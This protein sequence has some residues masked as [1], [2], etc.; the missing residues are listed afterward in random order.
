MKMGQARIRFLIPYFGK[1]PFWMPFFLQSCRYNPSIEWLFFSDCGPPENCPPNVEIRDLSYVGYCEMV[2]EQL[3]IE[4]APPN[5]YKLCDLKPALGFVH[6][7]CLDGF[8]F[9]G[10]G[11]ID[12]VYGNLRRYFDDERLGRYDLLFTHATRISGHLCLLRN[13]QKMLK[14]FMMVPGWQ[15]A[16]ADPAHRAFD[17]KAFSKLF[18]KNKNWPEPLRRFRRALSPMLRR[19]EFVEAFSTPYARIPWTDGSFDFPAQWVWRD[20]RLHTDRDGRRDFPYLHFLVWKGHPWAGLA[21]EQRVAE[22]DLAARSC[23]AISA[24]GFHPLPV[25]CG[26]MSR[27]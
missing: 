6:A 20:G 26:G 10:F 11:D 3:G 5:P 15:R 21:P 1:W 25:S 8:D 24:E 4:F 12:L 22:P 18:V 14:A 27:G 17:E 19:C 16:L 23:W 9:W 7:D 13:N 2:S